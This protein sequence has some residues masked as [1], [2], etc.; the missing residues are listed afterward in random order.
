VKESRLPSADQS[1]LDRCLHRISTDLQTPA[2]DLGAGTP[3]LA[4]REDADGTI[5][6]VP[7]LCPEIPTVVR[8]SGSRTFRVAEA[9]HDT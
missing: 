2:L 7:I 8:G 9:T 3:A 6:F 4:A 5:A 1:L